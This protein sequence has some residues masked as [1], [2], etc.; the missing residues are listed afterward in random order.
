MKRSPAGSGRKDV[1]SGTGRD[2]EKSIAF[3]RELERIAVRSFGKTTARA[4]GESER[5]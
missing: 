2:E 3:R 1:V 5:E 4:F